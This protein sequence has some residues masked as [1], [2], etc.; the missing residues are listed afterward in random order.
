[1]RKLQSQR[2][3]LLK[4]PDGDA[5]KLTMTS[6]CWQHLEQSAARPTALIGR[7]TLDLVDPSQHFIEI[8]QP[9]EDLAARPPGDPAGLGINLA[10]GHYRR[11]EIIK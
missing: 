11:R 6:N 7:Q 10:Q 1:M 5:P 9:H 3:D 4:L 8:D 2:I